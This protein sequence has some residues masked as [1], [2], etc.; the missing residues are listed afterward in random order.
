MGLRAALQFQ[1]ETATR[2]V[3]MDSLVKALR[4]SCE[5][6]EQNRTDHC[7]NVIQI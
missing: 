2:K 5:I 7:A 6:L 1:H 3:S 4:A